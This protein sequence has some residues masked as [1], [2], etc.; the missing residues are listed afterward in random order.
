MMFDNVAAEF[1][2]NFA[3]RGEVGA[4]FAAV[5]DGE[6]IVDLWG[7]VADPAT[8]RP[9]QRDTLQLVFSGAKGL[10]AAAILLLIQR[11]SVRLDAPVAHYWPEFAANGKSGITVA[12]VMSHQARMPALRSKVDVQD[13]L[14]PIAMAEMLAAQAPETDPRAEFIYHSFTYGWL[15]GEI[16]RRV[17]GRDVGRFF[18][19]EFAGPLDVDVWLGLPFEHHDRVATVHFGPDWTNFD[20]LLAGDDFLASLAN[21]VLIQPER[22]EFLNGF[23]FK[24]S[25][26]PAGGAIGTARGFALFYGRLDRILDPDIIRLGR[27]ELRGGRDTLFGYPMAHGVGFQLVTGDPELPD[28]FGH[29]GAGGSSH[30]TWPSLGVSYS[31]AM[32]CLSTTRREKCCRPLLLALN[33][34][35][36]HAELGFPR[37]APPTAVRRWGDGGHPPSLLAAV[38]DPG[39]GITRPS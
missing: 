3:S 18:A 14:D 23:D 28:W 13:V 38:R 10:V 31:Y 22:A 9:W 17:D 33:H 19:E 1:Q 12:Q 4:A 5:R 35:A 16:V 36:R 32:N 2:E 15:A 20:S 25:L 8:G 21:P 27:T 7:G 34:H 24:H 37:A 11:G 6:L 39:D 30:G 29:D 26:V